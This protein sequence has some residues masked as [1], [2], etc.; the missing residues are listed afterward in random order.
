MTGAITTYPDG[1]EEKL[2][3]CISY[4]PESGELRSIKGRKGGA[5]A[6]SVLGYLHPKGYLYL[7]F[8]GRGLI[9]H[10]VAW[11]L[12]Y[13][14]WPIEIDHWDTNKLNNAIY[15]LREVDGTTNQENKRRARIDN[16][17]SGLLGVRKLA[18]CNNRFEARIGINGTLISVGVF[19]TAEEAH[20]AYIEAK[21]ILHKGCTI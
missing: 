19:D 7:K 5:K 1:F 9:A 16:L 10:R 8:A 18:N 11:F 20:F 6:G 15:N 17:S 4:D 13:G 3:A 14:R 2:R 12:Y 21:R